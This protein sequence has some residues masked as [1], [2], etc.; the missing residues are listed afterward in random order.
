MN[1]RRILRM[2]VFV[3][4][5][6]G[7]YGKSKDANVAVFLT[8]AAAEHYLTQNQERLQVDGYILLLEVQQ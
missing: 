1:L 6:E 5:F 4:V 8:K 2:Q 3:V 7:W